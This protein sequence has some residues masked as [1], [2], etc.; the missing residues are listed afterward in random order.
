MG[1]T[2]H[3]LTPTKNICCLQPLL[4][5]T[6]ANIDMKFL[7][8]YAVTPTVKIPIKKEEEID[9]PKGRDVSL[10]CQV[11]SGFPQ[12]KIEWRKEEKI[13]PSKL[14]DPHIAVLELRKVQ[15]V[16]AGRYVCTAKNIAGRHNDDVIITVKCKYFCQHFHNF[17]REKDEDKS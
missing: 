6:Y 5:V 1:L 12:P 3:T 4:I 10:R 13:L 2:H 17:A 11:T 9:V 16:N 14:I 15:P 8:S 7:Y